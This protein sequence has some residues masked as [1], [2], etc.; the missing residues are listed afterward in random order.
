MNYPK[1][2]YKNLYDEEDIKK[3]LDEVPYLVN[4]LCRISGCTPASMQL[5]HDAMD[6]A[7]QPSSLVVEVSSASQTLLTLAIALLTKFLI[8]KKISILLPINHFV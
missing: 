6:D 4:G 8:F 1:E 7:S 2:E 3:F 5:E